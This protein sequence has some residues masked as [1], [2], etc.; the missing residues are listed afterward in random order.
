MQCCGHGLSVS[1]EGDGI[2]ATVG[3][4]GGSLLEEQGVPAQ[5]RSISPDEIEDDP[6]HD[7]DEHDGQQTDTEPPRGTDSELSPSQACGI[8]IVSLLIHAQSS[9]HPTP[10]LTFQVDAAEA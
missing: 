3:K 8:P 9:E 1:E 6:H 7:P 4:L 5:R 10:Q 2:P